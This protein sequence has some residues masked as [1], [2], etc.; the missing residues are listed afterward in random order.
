MLNGPSRSKCKLVK[1]E[2]QRMQLKWKVRVTHNVVLKMRTT[3][4]I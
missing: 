2:R 4:E 1:L 3:N